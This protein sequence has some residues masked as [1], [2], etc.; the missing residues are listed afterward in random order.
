MLVIYKETIE[1]SVAEIP[2]VVTVL[3]VMA[4]LESVINPL[5]IKIYE[6]VETSI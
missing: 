5:S 6:M 4:G 1:D 3:P 2:W